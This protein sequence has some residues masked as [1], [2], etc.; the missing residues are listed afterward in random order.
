MAERVL[1]TGGAGYVGSHACKALA[2]AGYE[3][4][5]LD[6]LS[7]GHTWAVKWGPLERANLMDEG[8]VDA[9]MA[10]YRPSAVLHFAGLIAVGQSVREPGRYYR[11]N[12]GTLLSLLDAMRRQG[13][14]RIV[15]S[16]SAAVYGDPVEV[17][18][19]ETHPLAPV[20]PYGASK[21]MCERILADCAAAGDVSAV[22]LRYF[23]AAAADPDSDIGE[24][25][26]PETH[27]IPLAIRAASEPGF[28][29]R[30]FGDDYPTPDGT[31][32]R[33][34]IHVSDL[35]DAHVAALRYLQAG[36]D[37][38]ALNLGTG[39]GHSV[40]E[41]L[42][43]AGEVLG[44]PVKRTMAPRRDG[45]PPRLVADPSRARRILAWEPR[46]SELRTIVETAARWHLRN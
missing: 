41:V 9:V 42:R 46:Y 28:T 7:G 11:A 1:V 32:V 3:P 5:C 23:N 44:R 8:A 21:R 15:F 16:S 18:I 39:Q 40:L 45:D 37:T 19:P 22:S 34:Y 36:G 20:N 2:G 14:G 43:A 35:A 4:I 30:V 6:D 10:R 29:L 25:H 38:T 24:A 12:V 27:L 26:D 33:D 31:A 17:P 13:V